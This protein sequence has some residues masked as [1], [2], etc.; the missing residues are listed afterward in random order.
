MCIRDRVGG[1]AGLGRHVHL[2]AA[3]A[4]AADHGDQLFDPG[5]LLR[6][7]GDPGGIGLREDHRP[8]RVRQRLEDLLGDKG[9]EGV[10]E[11]EDL[12]EHVEQHLLRGEL[13]LLVLAVQARLGQLDIP[14]A[15]AVP[16]EVVDLARGD[17]QLELC[18]LYTS[19]A[20][21]E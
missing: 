11:L 20:A 2:G 18:L 7:A 9:H 10:Q 14:V 8:I 5:G 13:R 4:D 1:G 12:G 15:V 21:D 6:I 19:D 16:D 17:A 3:G